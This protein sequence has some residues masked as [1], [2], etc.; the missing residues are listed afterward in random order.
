MNR[1]GAKNM[2]MKR[3]VAGKGVPNAGRQDFK[4]AMKTPFPPSPSDAT[5]VDSTVQERARKKQD[6]AISKQLGVARPKKSRA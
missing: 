2:G 5:G 1:V 4:R 6:G 3:P